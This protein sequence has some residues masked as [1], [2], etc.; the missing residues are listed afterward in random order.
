MYQTIVLLPSY[1][2]YDVS[3]THIVCKYNYIYILF[4]PLYLSFTCNYCV[5]SKSQCGYDIIMMYF[6]TINS[7]SILTD[8]HSILNIWK[9]N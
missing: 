6:L 2:T 7:T 4:L 1:V 5:K 8:F 3:D 9:K